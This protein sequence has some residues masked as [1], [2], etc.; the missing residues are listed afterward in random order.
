[1]NPLARPLVAVS[2]S[3][4]ALL[5]AC[6]SSESPSDGGSGTESG[7]DDSAGIDD[8]SC[9]CDVKHNGVSKKI[10]CGKSA[11][12]NGLSYTCSSSAQVKAGEECTEE[13]DASAGDGG[14]ASATF[15]CGSE[16]C[17]SKSEYCIVSQVGT[18]VLGSMCAALPSSCDSCDC[19]P[20]DAES[21]WKKKQNGTNNC[22]GVTFMC[23]AKNGEVTVTC[24][25]GKL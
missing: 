6:S 16:Q 5:S 20:D 3:I 12:V 22:T 23:S 8:S 9:V 13:D 24:S 25:K 17:D 7:S 10:S 4:V 21:A 19:A 1:M 2:F 18:S 15:K 14:S 11:C